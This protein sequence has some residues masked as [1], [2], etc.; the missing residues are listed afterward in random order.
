[1]TC[2]FKVAGPFAQ[3]GQGKIGFFTASKRV[4]QDFSQHKKLN[5]TFV[6]YSNYHTIY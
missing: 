2:F 1:M 6:K 4:L 5:A 3:V